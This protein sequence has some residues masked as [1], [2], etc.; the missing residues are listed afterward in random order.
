LQTTAAT[1]VS[2]TQVKTQTFGKM[3]KPPKPSLANLTES[4]EDDLVTY[5]QEHPILWDRGGENY[6][7]REKKIQTWEVKAKE[8]GLTWD[9][10]STWF[11]SQRTRLFFI[12]LNRILTVT[13]IVII[14][15]IIYFINFTFDLTVIEDTLLINIAN[16]LKINI[17][18]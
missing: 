12:T 7:D 8:Y 13:E 6:K 16:T 11:N 15:I 18:F 1:G 3:K 2:D 10:L 17:I 5:I 9:K 4:Q 14:V